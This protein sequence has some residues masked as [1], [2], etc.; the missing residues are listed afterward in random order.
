VNDAGATPSPISRARHAWLAAQSAIWRDRGLIDDGTRIHILASYTTEAA[1]RR[2]ML[3]LVLLAVL[4]CGIGLLLLIGYNWARIPAAV[5]VAMVCSAVAAAF[6]GAAVAYA[7]QRML[8]GEILALAGTFV[9]GNGIWLIA[10]V[11]HIAGHFPDAFFWFGIGALAAAVLL[12]SWL[13]GA[14]AT[15]IFALWI[16]ADGVTSPHPSFVFVAIWIV[17]AALAL[18][19]PSPAMLHGVALLAPAWVLSATQEASDGA[20]WLGAATLAACAVY[21]AGMWRRADDDLKRAWQDG[22]LVAL[23]LLVAP[24]MDTRVHDDIEPARAGIVSISIAAALAAAALSGA[25]R[26]TRDPK[27]VA[28]LCAAS[29]TVVWM[30]MVATGASPHGEITSI[31]SV[32]LFSGVA[33]GM[34]VALIRAALQSNRTVDVALGVLFGLAFLLV[35]WLSVVENL[36]W[37]GLLLLTAGAGLLLVA[38]LWRRRPRP[39]VAV[40]A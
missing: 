17:L 22:G 19:I 10:D 13:I 1:E 38:R 34:S 5:K 20:V 15:F 9:F 16:F 7:R 40:G 27:D 32:L 2:G 28:V 21:C 31:V 3:A 39:P 26:R 18:R 29:V 4:M 37:S 30:L 8:V 36:L 35:R 6:A 25:L 23:L 12:R 24:L 11:L 33:L 14:G